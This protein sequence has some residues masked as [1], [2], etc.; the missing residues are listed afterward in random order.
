MVHTELDLSN[1]AGSSTSAPAIAAAMS[2]P[3]PVVEP[4]TRANLPSRRNPSSVDAVASK[5]LRRT[6]RMTSENNV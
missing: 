2:S 5:S 4:V 3:M 1:G 6:A